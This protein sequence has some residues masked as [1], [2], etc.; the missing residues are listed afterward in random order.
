M[1]SIVLV[2]VHSFN[3]SSACCLASSFL[4]ICQSA[5]MLSLMLAMAAF[6]HQGPQH[7]SNTREGKPNLVDI[8]FDVAIKKAMSWQPKVDVTIAVIPSFP[9]NMYWMVPHW[10]RM[11]GK[12]LSG[13]SILK[14]HEKALVANRFCMA[15]NLVLWLAIGFDVKKLMLLQ[16]KFDF[17]IKVIP[18]S[19]VDTYWMVPYRTMNGRNCWMDNRFRHGSLSTLMDVVRIALFVFIVWF[20]YASPSDNITFFLCPCGCR[21][22]MSIFRSAFQDKGYRAIRRRHFVC[23]RRENASTPLPSYRGIKNCLLPSFPCF[24]FK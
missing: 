19:I 21:V 6:R 22:S 3:R 10:T 9:V 16:S 5:F 1:S 8:D 13:R 4:L 7:A 15:F 11:E 12:E 20:L 2:F 18:S 14:W 17:A 23:G 24:P